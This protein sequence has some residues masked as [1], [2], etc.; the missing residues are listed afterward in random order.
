[1]KLYETYDIHTHKIYWWT[2]RDK[3][4]NCYEIRQASNK[5]MTKKFLLYINE[6]Y[7]KAFETFAEAENKI[8]ELWE[9]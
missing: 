6:H 7:N 2:Q 5:F 3:N 9:V 8:K 1:M 4:N